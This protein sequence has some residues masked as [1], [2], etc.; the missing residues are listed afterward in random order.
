MVDLTASDINAMI[1]NEER[2]NRSLEFKQ[3]LP[4]ESEKE[5]T[6]FLSDVAAMA[7]GGGGRLLYGIKE[8]RTPGEQP[9][10][11]AGEAVGVEA[12]NPGQAVLRLEQILQRGIDP[13]V[14]GCRFYSVAG[15][16]KG[17]V[18][19]LEVRRSWRAPH[20]V[21]YQDHQLFYSRRGSGKYRLDLSEIRAAFLSSEGVETKIRRFHDERLGRILARE[22]PVA[23]KEG[24]CAVLHVLPVESF[25][26]SVALHLR[27]LA[28]Q[29]N[30][31]APSL[32]SARFNVDGALFHRG[33]EG[34]T[35]DGYVQVFRTG[36]IESVVAEYWRT[37][38]HPSFLAVEL[39]EKRLAELLGGQ[40]SGLEAVGVALPV[41]VVGALLNARGYRVPIPQLPWPDVGPETTI[42]RDVVNLP[43]RM[44]EEP[45]ETADHA[46][47]PIFEAIYQASG[48]AR[49][50]KV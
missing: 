7:N 33:L 29:K 21:C 6:E 19:V 12:P 36:A 1:A 3:D 35:C 14:P 22:T 25:S 15:F 11:I 9:T 32:P 18:I 42:D 43:D 28:E 16:E 27:K 13:R 26:G 45:G 34:G 50:E 30:H 8:K 10:G 17:P 23:T 47:L 44:L 48:Y 31:F 41:V 46:L 38:P 4:G 37:G 24:P 20:M 40:L 2:E 39:L 49:P 5:K